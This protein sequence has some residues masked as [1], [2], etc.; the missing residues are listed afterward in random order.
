MG[1]RKYRRHRRWNRRPF[2]MVNMLRAIRQK[3]KPDRKI[4]EIRHKYLLTETDRISYIYQINL[5]N[6]VVEVT[7]VSYDILLKNQW[8]T[9][10]YY[11]NYH[12]GILHRHV[13]LNLENNVDVPNIYGVKQKGTPRDLLTWA[14]RDL[15]LNYQNY[16]AG[17]VRR[18]KK[19]L[20]DHNIDI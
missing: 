15:R 17:F 16:R 19:Y 18:N 4:H 20:I 11:D 9:L 1:N 6:V 13:S 2:S 7:C 5:Q 12:G 3:R 8:V 10:I 14:N